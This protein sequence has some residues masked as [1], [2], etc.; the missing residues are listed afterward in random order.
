MDTNNATAI[1]IEFSARLKA[2]LLDRG[3]SNSATAI[4]REF[5]RRANETL[6]VHAVRKWLVG[7]AIPAQK[8][9]LVLADWLDVEPA[10]LRFGEGNRDQTIAAV[11]RP[12]ALSPDVLL[13]ARDIATL[14]ARWLPAVRS[15]ITTLG[16][17]QV[18]A[19]AKAP[20]V[21]PVHDS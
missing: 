1:R 2:T 17:L 20:P 8:N 12:D 11:A 14:P 18:V 10:W 16:E 6:T 21:S 13:I 9:L 7:G 3:L 19:D 5:Q 15:L 4:A